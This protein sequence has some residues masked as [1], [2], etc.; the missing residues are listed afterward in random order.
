MSLSLDGDIHSCSRTSLLNCADNRDS[1]TGQG[2]WE[3]L[4]L[5]V[6]C[7]LR[8]IV[9]VFNIAA[10]KGSSF[11]S[12]VNEVSHVRDFGLFAP[13]RAPKPQVRGHWWRLLT[14]SLLIG[15]LCSG[16]SNEAV[17]SYERDCLFERELLRLRS[18]HWGRHRFLLVHS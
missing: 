10:E 17:F 13:R 2:E 3:L 6:Q 15:R 9:C 11:G 7:P 4:I 5:H 18:V 14:C 8:E 16:L 12:R 1:L